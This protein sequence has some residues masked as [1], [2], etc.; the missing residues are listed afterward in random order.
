VSE[1]A[2]IPFHG[3]EVLAVEIDGKPHVILK[4]A[5]DHIG[6]DSDQQIRKLKN[7]PWSCTGVTPVQV[8]N[9]VRNMI[10]ADVRTFLMALATIPVSRVNEAARPLLTSYQSEVADVIEQYWTQG[11]AINPR[12]TEDQLSVLAARAESQMRVLKLADGLVDP[13]WLET[14]VRHVAARALGEEPEIDPATRPLSV[15]EF[16]S[17]MGVSGSEQRRIASTFGKRVK[18]AYRE[19]YK[20]EPPTVERFVDGALRRVAGYTEAHRHLFNHVWAE[21]YAPAA[22]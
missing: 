21:Y 6:L 3:S 11:G 1:I 17:D 20:N 7:Q 4:P 9:Q 15:G 2:K 10:T 5:F 18:A 16:L 19:V 12:A 13:A 14:K 22:A 8:G